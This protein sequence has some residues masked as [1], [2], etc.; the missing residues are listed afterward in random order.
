MRGYE[1]LFQAFLYFSYF[2]YLGIAIGVLANEP[3][4]F[5]YMKYYME[6]FIALFLMW[7]FRPNYF[8]P[9]IPTKWDEFDRKI[10]FSAGVFI[11]T[12]TLLE[13]IYLRIQAQIPSLPNIPI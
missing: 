12:T 2:I 8:F 5:Q 4:Y 7:R 9:E 10:A 11:L 3:L 1:H 13:P 6:F